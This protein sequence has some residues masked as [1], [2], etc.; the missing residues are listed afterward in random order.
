MPRLLIKFGLWPI[1]SWSDI[2]KVRRGT[3]Y[4]RE[5]QTFC[6]LHIVLRTY[7]AVFNALGKTPGGL[8]PTT[9]AMLVF[10]TCADQAAPMLFSLGNSKTIVRSWPCGPCL[11]GFA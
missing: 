3:D 4:L 10:F 5:S 11:L 7:S 2:T 6:V 1:T 8:Q 9:L